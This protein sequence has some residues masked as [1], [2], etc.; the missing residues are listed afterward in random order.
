MCLE[1]KFYLCDITE[2]RMK[3][4]AY[5]GRKRLHMLSDVASSARYQEVKTAAKTERNGQLQIVLHNA[6]NLLHSRV[7]NDD[8]DD[9]DG[10]GGGDSQKQSTI[11]F[12]PL[13]KMLTP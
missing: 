3:G 5:H 11:I 6:I 12:L 8:D 13:L 9:D 4:T 7:L 2:G 10:G 1:I